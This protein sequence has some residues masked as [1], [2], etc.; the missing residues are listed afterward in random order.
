MMKTKIKTKYR[1]VWIVLL[2]LTILFIWGHSLF[3]RE[4]SA[5]ESGFVVKILEMIFGTG[6]VSENLIRKIAHLIEY[7]ALGLELYIL[8]G[9]YLLSAV[10]GLFVALVD[11]TIQLFVQRGSGVLDVW[12]DF[13]GVLFGALIALLI[14]SRAGRD[15]NAIK[16]E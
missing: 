14:L 2:I 1:N 6:N 15:Q 4:A 11:E 9:K 10:H 5:E 8:F 3:S 13:S 7:S 16:K 12:L